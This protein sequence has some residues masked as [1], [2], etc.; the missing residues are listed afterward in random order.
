MKFF[1]LI[2]LWY[3]SVCPTF[4]QAAMPTMQKNGT[5][6]WGTLRLKEISKDGMWL[7]CYMFYESGKDTLFVINTKSTKLI[8]VPYGN[9]PTFVKEFLICQIKDSI[10]IVNL[11]SGKV[12]KILGTEL[13]VAKN[14]STI[15]YLNKSQNSSFLV[16]RISGKVLFEIKN[17]TNF[18]L[19]PD[20]N[21]ILYSGKEKELCFSGIIDLNSLS[22]NT[23]VEEK[24]T[25]ENLQWS[26]KCN[27]V[28]FLKKTG[29]MTECEKIFYYNINTNQLIEHR[30]ADT[31][32]IVSKDIYRP[33]FSEDG[34]KI[35]FNVSPR[36][37]KAVDSESVEIWK[38]S[39]SWTYNLTSK[40]D[41]GNNIPKL[42]MWIPSKGKLKTIT[43]NNLLDARIICGGKFALLSNPRQYKREEL[44]YP[45]RDY[46][47]MDLEK[48]TIELLLKE[49][50]GQPEEIRVSPDGHHLIYYY[51][52]WKITTIKQRSLKL[53]LGDNLPAWSGNQED[54]SRGRLF[55]F[56]GFSE[57]GNC[58]FIYDKFDIWQ[59]AMENPIPKRIT[60]G[61]ELNVRFRFA[62]RDS[63]FIQSRSGSDQYLNKILSAYNFS[64]GVSGYFEF[65]DGKL[66]KLA[67]ENDCIDELVGENGIYAYRRQS[68]SDSPFAMHYSHGKSK[69]VYKSNLSLIKYKNGFS[70]ML[71]YNTQDQVMP[72]AVFYPS[73][74]N[75]N[76]KYP[77][78]VHVYEGL[79]REVHQFVNP[80]MRNME[81]FNLANETSDGYIAVMPDIHYTINNPGISSSQSLKD[82]ADHLV[83]LGIAD[84]N[85]I[86]L[87]GHSFG[88][89]EA[90]FAMT[91][92]SVFATAVAGSGISDLVFSYHSMSKYLEKPEMWRFEDFQLRFNTPF[93]LNNRAYLSNSPLI[94]AGKVK[95]PILIYSGK[96][97]N[98][99]LYQQSMAFY[100]ALRRVGIPTNLLLYP[101]EQHIILKEE[102]QIDLTIRIKDWM[103]HYLKGHP[104]KEWM[105]KAI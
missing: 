63:K 7:S 92:T 13:A 31:L 65:K 17:V 78:I 60:N 19:S 48:D 2:S 9:K 67:F 66:K 100:L 79:S 68:F 36:T 1:I 12:S 33:F 87:I 22:N 75:H 95:R 85:R 74:Y 52:G 82:L 58:F 50:S 61:K 3:I 5:G 28:S 81:G 41:K 30:T 53:V 59:V 42:Q 25:F 32:V 43:N 44:Q 55:G 8:A 45:P 62:L 97:D 93:H 89:Y 105:D 47:L 35:F 69:L 70:K 10:G 77:V 103:D 24:G 101:K 83:S 39:D 15:F 6:K 18:I 94:H 64:T 23:L 90:F 21:K 49:Q 99:I 46:Y 71:S 4:G 73:N 57:N 72:M 26:P 34:Q 14:A 80:S 76:I 88:G 38:G 84:K 11:K 51:K 37:L 20:E 56:G 54:Y 104:A 102:N 86:G 98:N 16:Q 40:M 29:N 96:N 27:A 91:D